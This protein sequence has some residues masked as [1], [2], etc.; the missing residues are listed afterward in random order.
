MNFKTLTLGAA[1]AGLMSIPAAMA[2]DTPGKP[3]LGMGKDRDNKMFEMLDANK[4]GGVSLDEFLAPHQK[5]F[6]EIDADKN[7]AIS[8]EEM[9]SHHEAMREKMKQYREMKK[10]GTENPAGKPTE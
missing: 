8:A 1:L 9:K 2:E 7:G 3:P 5:R 10:D 6:V 4:D